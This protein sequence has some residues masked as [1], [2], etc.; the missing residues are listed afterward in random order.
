MA[1]TVPLCSH[2]TQ[3]LLAY[4]LMWFFLGGWRNES[5]SVAF[6]EEECVI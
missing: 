6:H 3:D 5:Y 4:P 1:P 2:R